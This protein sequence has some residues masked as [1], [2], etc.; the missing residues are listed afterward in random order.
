MRPDQ[1]KP[2]KQRILDRVE[3][4]AD[5]CWL[6]QG[7]SRTSSGHGRMY[8]G[9][10]VDGTRRA[11]GPHRL[12]WEEMF[13][14]IPDGLCVLHECDVPRCVN[15][16]HLFLGTQLDNMADRDAKGRQARGERQGLAKLT[17]EKVKTMRYAYFKYDIPITDMARRHGV[18]YQ[19]VRAVILGH[20]WKHV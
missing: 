18:T 14:S 16:E 5:G 8:V 3:K 19:A 11:V 10:M 7:K 17:A 2:I 9:S 1:A 15:P 20:T 6:W 12:M 4:Q 13:G